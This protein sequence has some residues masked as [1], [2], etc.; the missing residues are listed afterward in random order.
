MEAAYYLIRMRFDLKALFRLGPRPAPHRAIDLGYLIHCSLFELFGEDGPSPFAIAG[1][2]GSFLEVLAY[3]RN[4]HFTLAAKAETSG[5]ADHRLAFDW[6]Y[7]DSKPMP[8]SF[9]RGGAFRFEVRACPVVRKGRGSKRFSAGAE[10]DAFLAAVEKVG[11][12]GV[13]EREK[14]YTT[15]LKE[16]IER[17]CAVRCEKARLVAMKRSRLFRRGVAKEAKF[18]DR[19][20]VTFEGCLRVTD[21]EGF[22]DL[23]LRGI[24]RHRAF[25]FG[26]LLLRRAGAC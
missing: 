9:P 11:P 7:F 12:D 23:L 19:P 13:V 24:G 16:T 21:P 1:S 22:R 20:D 18:F 17:S 10:V 2:R 4:P 5:S 15:W 3:A 25:G 14:V 8:A 26:M 6:G